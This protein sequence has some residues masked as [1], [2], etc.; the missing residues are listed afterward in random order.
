MKE[1]IVSNERKQSSILHKMGLNNTKIYLECNLTPV[2]LLQQKK[3][4]PLPSLSPYQTQ[5]DHI[6][7]KH[8]GAIQTQYA[9]L[10][11][12]S[13]P[14]QLN[15]TEMYTMLHVTHILLIFYP[16]LTHIS[17]KTCLY[18]THTSSLYYLHISHQYI[19]IVHIL[20]ASHP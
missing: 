15:Q 19:T 14:I 7:I 11:H 4:N 16:Y 1:I 3:G 12:T 10:Q 20:L 9:A 8:N 2:Y 5:V 18:I 17:L 6:L 13:S